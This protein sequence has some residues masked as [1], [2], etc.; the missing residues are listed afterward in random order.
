SLKL[1]TVF[2][3]ISTEKKLARLM[4]MELLHT[5]YNI[6]GP[7]L[8]NAFGYLIFYSLIPY[9]EEIPFGFWG[10]IIAIVTLTD[11]LSSL[12]LLTIFHFA[13]NINTGQDAWDFIRARSFMDTLKR[14]IS[15]GLLYVF[16]MEG[17][18]EL[19]IA[20]FVLN[21]LVSRSGILQ[22]KSIQHKIERDRFEHMA[23]TDFLTKIYNRTYMNKIMNELNHS[24][25]KIGIIVTDIDTF[26]R[27]N[28]KYNHAVGDAVIQSFAT[29]LDRLLGEEDYLF[30]SGG[31]EFTIFL[32]KKSYS[33]CTELVQRLQQEVERA[34]A[35]CEFRSKTIKISY[36]ASFGLYYFQ[37][38]PGNDI[39]SAYIHADDL[40]FKA[41]NQGKNQASV[42]NG[43]QDTPLSV[44]YASLGP[45]E[46][47]KI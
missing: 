8:L 13:G 45:T 35:H 11:F 33:E 39:K 37:C 15:N 7:A 31:E 9:V 40:L 44:R 32:R 28:D 14:G 2:T 4:K 38:N 17:Q 16:L 5:F 46:K 20:L 30:R 25:E 27:V 3:S 23:Y 36:T 12:L 22:S 47:V 1:L 6:G 26:K 29:T 24:A 43:I 34:P 41:K 42:K 19:L 21:Y 18:W 10:L